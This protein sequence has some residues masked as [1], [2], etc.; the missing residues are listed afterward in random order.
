VAD[1][2]DPFRAITRHRRNWHPS[3]VQIPPPGEVD[4]WPRHR[5]AAR[6]EPPCHAHGHIDSVPR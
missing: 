4:I 2:L 5:M 3:A 1:L 6:V